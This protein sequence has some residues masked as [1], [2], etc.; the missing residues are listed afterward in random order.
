[1]SA[2]S[3]VSLASTLFSLQELTGNSSTT[4]TTNGTNGSTQS[5]T[6]SAFTQLLLTLGTSETQSTNG[7]SGVSNGSAGPFGGLGYLF[8]AYGGQ[9]DSASI[10]G[11]AQFISELQQLQTQNPTEFTQFATQVATQLQSAAT[12]AGQTP[13]GQFLTNLANQY[14][15]LANGAS[16]SQ[17][18]SGHHQNA[19]GIYNQN[20]Q[21]SQTTPLSPFQNWGASAGGVNLQQLFSNI[22]SEL[23]QALSVGATGST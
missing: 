17:V 19:Q 1:M 12:Q 3:G 13:E 6:E 22:S 8:G 5:T 21:I 20:G 2:I 18:F 9:G 4:T 7:T 16:V 23:S 10:S 14:E 15:Q 11:P